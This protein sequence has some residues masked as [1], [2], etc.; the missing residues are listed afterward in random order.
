MKLAIMQPYFFPY[1]GYFQLINAVDKFV[2][3]DDVQYIK[4]GWISKNRVL[5]NRSGFNIGIPVKKD[6]SIKNI[7]E[8][9]YV[10]NSEIFKVKLLRQIENA[11]GK[12][13]FYNEIFPFIS[14]LL[15]T[16]EKNVSK[17]NTF[18]LFEICKL[19]NISTQF[20]NSSEMIKQDQLKGEE[21]VLNIN[22][23]LNSD[24]YINP[25][26][27][28]DLYKRESFRKR[29]IELRFLVSDKIEYKQSG[30]DFIPG[31]SIVDVLM[32]NS[33]QDIAALLNQYHLE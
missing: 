26:G 23:V 22:Q 4:G 5:L 31:L 8:R 21:R 25:A 3:H 18:I 33:I 7:N 11:Y 10:A 9:Y 20:V 32:F 17:F 14:G 2:I 19:L 16:G 24:V 27:G 6:S 15:L 29:N 13:P 1:I 30:G 28:T 12:A